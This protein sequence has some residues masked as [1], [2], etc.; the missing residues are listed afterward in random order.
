MKNNI[1]FL[2][3]ALLGT[4]SA[5]AQLP[6]SIPNVVKATYVEYGR[7]IS[8]T[9]D[10]STTSAP[11][12]TSKELG[13]K[14]SINSTNLLF[15]LLPGVE[16]MQN[17]GNAWGDGATLFIRGV[18]TTNNAYPLVLVD[19]FERSID[20]LSSSDIESVT[21]LKDAVSTSLYGI[22]GA[23]GVILVKTKRGLNSTPQ[24]NFSYQFNMGT[25]RNLPQ[26]VDGY[27]YA[28][29]L[30]E[31][32]TNDGS[33]PRYNRYELRAF[34][35]GK[36]PDFFPNVDW[37]NE[38]LRDHSYGNNVTF[39]AQGG[40]EYVKYYTQL[41]YL[42][43]SGILKPTDW[44]DG[45]STQFKYSRLNIR[46]NLDIKLS[47]T[48]KAQL[49]MYGSFSEQNRPGK[50]S[51]DIFNALY[52]VP[53]G[54]FPIKTSNGVFGGTT[55]YANNPIAYIAG[56]GYSRTQGRVLFA[57]FD[58]KQDLNFITKGLTFGVKVALDNYSSYYDN[59]IKDF[60]YE[61]PVMDVATGSQK[62]NTLRNE[63]ELTYGSS[64]STS[65]NHFNFEVRTDYNK[66]WGD[67]HQLGA[68]LLYSMDKNIVKDRNKTTAF[69]DVVAQAHYTFRNRY[70]LDASLS[71]SASSVLSPGNRWGT[72][73]SVGMAWLLSEES[74]LK[75]DWV[76]LLKFRTSYGIA[77]RANYGANLYKDAYTSGGGYIFGETLLG[78]KGMYE[79]RLGISDLTY[80]KSHKA[81]V[82]VDFLG[83]NKLSFT[84]DAF[85][86]HRTD[87]LVDASGSISSVLGITVPNQNDGEIDSYGF[88]VAAKWGD[89]IRDFTYHVGGM[90]SYNKTKII[91]MDEQYRP[92]DYQ[93]RTGK[94]VG[95]IFGYEVEGIYQSQQQID[96]REI[97]QYLSDVHPGDLMFKDQNNDN[98][99]DE[100]DMV[101]LG[102][103]TRCP[104][105]Y[106]SLDLGVEYKGIGLYA[107]FQGTGNY[108]KIMDMESMY[109]PL[110]NDNTISKH[111]YQ[112]RWTP[113]TPNALYP[114][115]T[116]EG[117]ANNYNTNSLWVADASYLKLRT[118]EL[119]Y[120]VPSALLRNSG[121]LKGARVFARVHDLFSWD[122]I[123][124]M[125]PEA[126]GATHPLMTQYTFGINF[127]F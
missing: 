35:N 2:M 121:V 38:A 28:Q 105:L 37:V 97:K 5:F 92:Y 51:G 61:M 112:N 17:A 41:N 63:G 119:Y 49:N 32:L 108:S 71:G 109:R 66:A 34:Q 12:V 30:N 68:S 1:K 60:G 24:I 96:E 83:W 50:S 9:L 88:E 36:Y 55:T 33:K 95:Q 54:A 100:N 29:A 77:G 16:V 67:D 40:G 8:H 104:E 56:S 103:N 42:N 64:V 73:P 102:Y 91:K 111:Y 69:M 43:D 26:F 22:K 78:V 86:D 57:D 62:Y 89:H 47:N 124:G 45:Y 123:N 31:G 84:L 52:K 13:H 79:S 27:T 90:F 99:I 101:A 10:Q 116:Y 46:T 59:N 126:M 75:A 115:L 117:S 118:L 6:D 14:T 39:S 70:I 53:S 120:Q 72:F 113:E 58:L 87:I 125:D 44:N 81:N 48:T 122:K 65:S 80:E 94:S 98:R 15:G 110:V 74:F 93:R 106:Y 114:R 82:G 85:Y 23:N 20:D 127:S 18:G 25:P 7:G 76:N 107:L 11:Q 19:G 3:F 21:V 4:S